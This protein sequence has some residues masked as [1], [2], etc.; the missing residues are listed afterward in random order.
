[1]PMMDTFLTNSKNLIYLNSL[2]DEVA[3]IW[4]RPKIRSSYWFLL[5]RYMVELQTAVGAAL[6]F[7]GLSTSVSVTR[8]YMLLAFT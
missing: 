5:N 1:M 3:Y 7:A 6:Q 8:Y 4:L 2:G